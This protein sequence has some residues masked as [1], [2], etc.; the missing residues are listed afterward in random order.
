[1]GSFLSSLCASEGAEKGG[2]TGVNATD[3]KKPVTDVAEG[4]EEV[5]F[6]AGCFWGTQKVPRCTNGV[7]FVLILTL[8]ITLTLYYS[9]TLQYF[10]VNFA[11]K[12]P[13]VQVK[14]SGTVGFMGPASAKKNPSYQEVCSGATGHVEVYKVQFKADAAGENFRELVK[15]FYQFHD[16]TT[17]NRQGNDTGTQ[18]ASVLYC[19]NSKQM[20]MAKDTNLLLGDYLSTG[21][22]KFEKNREFLG[23]AV[24][25]DLRLAT[26]VSIYTCA[27]IDDCMPSHTTCGST[28]MLPTTPFHCYCP[29]VPLALTH[30]SFLLRTPLCCPH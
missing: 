12:F 28:S 24:T 19:Y 30:S 26:E 1:M 7:A 6:G 2:V 27:Y 13:E 11:E 15:W 17:P 14:G 16:P 21:K 18:Y 3:T 20:R 25:T 22:I 9:P 8:T 23:S 5:C 29:Q 10:E 4:V